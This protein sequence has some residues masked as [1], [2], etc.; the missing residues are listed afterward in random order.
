MQEVEGEIGVR[1]I[2]GGPSALVNTTG[3]AG[4]GGECLDRVYRSRTMRK[5]GITRLGVIL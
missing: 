5:N 4:L 1:I 3:V 2:L